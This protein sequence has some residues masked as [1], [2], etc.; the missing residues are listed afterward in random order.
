LNYYKKKIPK[1]DSLLLNYQKAKQQKAWMIDQAAKSMLDKNK[2]K[3]TEKWSINQLIFHLYNVEKSVLGYIKHK[4]QKGELNQK[5][6]LK[7]RIRY[8]SLKMLLMTKMKFKAPK[9]LEQNPEVLDFDELL[10]NWTTTQKEFEEFLKNF[11]KDI[12]GKAVFKHPYA[13]FLSIQQT[14][15]FVADHSAHHKT[16]M[17]RLV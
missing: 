13:G 8:F 17:L 2:I 5:V 6:G 10:T 4:H 15:E 3:S 14:I 1:M 11:P 12:I 9:V 16:Q 7:A